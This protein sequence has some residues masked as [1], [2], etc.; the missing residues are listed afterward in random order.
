[1]KKGVHKSNTCTLAVDEVHHAYGSKYYM[2]LL[3][4]QLY[5]SIFYIPFTLTNNFD[6]VF[7]I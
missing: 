6:S 4:L 1:M 2:E 7:T 3:Y 5:L